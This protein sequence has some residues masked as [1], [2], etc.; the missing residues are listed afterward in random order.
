MEETE[1]ETPVQAVPEPETSKK[2]LIMLGLATVG[3]VALAK[4]GFDKARRY[5]IVNKDDLDALKNQ[6]VP[7]AK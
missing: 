7:E 3:A 5:R 2:P 6:P 1:F 4:K